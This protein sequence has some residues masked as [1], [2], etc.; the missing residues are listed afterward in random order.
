[1]HPGHCSSDGW[2]M[3]LRAK[4]QRFDFR[5]S[6]KFF[7]FHLNEELTK[8][9]TRTAR[10]RVIPWCLADNNQQQLTLLLVLNLFS[11]KMIRR[12]IRC[13]GFLL[14]FLGISQWW[15]SLSIN[16]PN[17]NIFWKFLQYQEPNLGHLCAKRPRPPPSAVV[18]MSFPFLGSVFCRCSNCTGQVNQDVVI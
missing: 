16:S 17:N 8:R 9:W 2:A 7:L 14:D 18:F 12:S 5:V 13:F 3:I 10:T 1:M 6:Q 15:M 11:I 4:G